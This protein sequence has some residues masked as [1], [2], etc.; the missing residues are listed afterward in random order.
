M[1]VNNSNP[2]IEDLKYKLNGKEP[3]K[4]KLIQIFGEVVLPI[5]LLIAILMF[6]YYYLYKPKKK[7][8]Q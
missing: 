5:I 4:D 7:E 1:L 3:L 2:T 6:A 8:E